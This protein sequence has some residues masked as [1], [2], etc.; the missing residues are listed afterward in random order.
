MKYIFTDYHLLFFHPQK[1]AMKWCNLIYYL[2]ELTIT[3]PN[4]NTKIDHNWKVYLK[5][6]GG[7]LPHW[8]SFCLLVCLCTF[9]S[10]CLSISLAICLSICLFAYLCICEILAA[11]FYVCMYVPTYVCMY[12]S[13]CLFVTL[14][15]GD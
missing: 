15:C 9:L 3:Q 13:V 7:N 14:N 1:Q 6:W 4:N 10:F 12:V 8:L 11:Y 5:F 2:A